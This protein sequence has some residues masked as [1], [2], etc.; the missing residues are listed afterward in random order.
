MSTGGIFLLLAFLVMVA[1]F[2]IW[3]LI[4]K[5]E[6]AHRTKP[7]QLEQLHAEHEAVLIAIRDLDFDYQTGKLLQQDYTTQRELLIQRGVEL[8]K[9]ID[10]LESDTI[11]KAVQVRRNKA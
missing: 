10:A 2:V 11:E 9:Q 3:P 8:L 1:V 5:R 6:T 4:I 7:S